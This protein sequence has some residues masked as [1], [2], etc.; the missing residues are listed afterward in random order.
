MKKTKRQKNR[1]KGFGYFRSMDQ[2]RD[3][4]KVPAEKKLEWLEEMYQLNRLVA[5]HNPKIAK[6]Q[7]M[8]RKGEM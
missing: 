7:E 8:F 5:I 2:I 6:I 3:Y 1:L 4:I